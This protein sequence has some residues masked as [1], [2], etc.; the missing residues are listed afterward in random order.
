MDRRLSHEPA[1]T[2]RLVLSVVVCH[3]Y[4]TMHKELIQF[5]IM[6]VDAK[7][8]V[9]TFMHAYFYKEVLQL[10]PLSSI[11][12]LFAK[13]HVI[14]FFPNDLLIYFP[15]VSFCLAKY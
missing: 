5:Y 15:T 13:K 6:C 1:L 12:S 8:S 2:F 4:S 7:E 14:F 10:L 9:F 11:S 3:R